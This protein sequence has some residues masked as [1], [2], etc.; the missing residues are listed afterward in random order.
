MEET[1]TVPLASW[2]F[3]KTEKTHTPLPWPGI[4][5]LMLAV[6]EDAIHS[7]RSSQSLVRAEAEQWMT[8]RER[9]YVF[10]FAVICDT[11][12]LEPSAVRRSVMDLVATKLTPGGPRRRSRP[13]IRHRGPI[14]LARDRHPRLKVLLHERA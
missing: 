5:A 7:L 1:A 3:P 11:L 13:N 2:E 8:S 9:R 6:L 10:S 4:R 12:D 14:R